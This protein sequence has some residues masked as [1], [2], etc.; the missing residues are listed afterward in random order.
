MKP[1]SPQSTEALNP[2]CPETLE[3]LLSGSSPT[4]DTLNHD[5][6]IIGEQGRSV[7]KE[8]AAPSAI[9]KEH[10]SNSHPI[11]T[12]FQFRGYDIRRNVTS[13]HPQ[14][15]G[16]KIVR[17]ERSQNVG[18]QEAIR[19]ID[20]SLDELMQRY[21]PHPEIRDPSKSWSGNTMSYSA[22]LKKGPF[23][24]TISGNICV[25][26]Q[27]VVVD[28][29]L[30]RVITMFVSEAKIRDVIGEWLDGLFRA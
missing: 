7:A 6:K 14:T 23:G 9:R 8:M 30:P 13:E 26:D 28:S 12:L 4:Q 1:E 29:D 18:Q 11:P 24:A 3:T 27:S 22:R 16:K 20:T 2:D 17:I 15:R 5:R 10:I 19:R 21:L 25:T